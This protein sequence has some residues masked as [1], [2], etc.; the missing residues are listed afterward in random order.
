VPHSPF[1]D[2]AMPPVS[3][4]A[5]GTTSRRFPSALKMRLATLIGLL[6]LAVICT[7][8]GG[9]GTPSTV[10][11]ST[12]CIESGGRIT[13]TA[14]FPSA[15]VGS[16]FNSVVT[17]SGGQAPYQFAI[18]WG[19]LPPGLSIN[20]KT[21]TVSGTPQSAGTYNFAITATDLPHKDYGDH[22]FLLDVAGSGGHQI[23]VAISPTSATL[24]SGTTQQFTA[25]VSGT[26]NTAVTWS[27][28]LGTISS[29]GLFTAPT[30]TTTTSV[31]VTATSV[32]D[33]M[34]KA[35]AT[36]TV[37]PKSSGPTIT[38]TSIPSATEGSPYSTTLSATG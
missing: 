7:S 31:T 16:G 2:G 17:V 5:V 23:S 27:A 4:L 10:F 8:C 20:S 33:P 24:T 3:A 25:T 32:A 13:V 12:Q 9:A 34:K 11:S 26:S 21:G 35:S 36:V 19:S 28:S 37:N 38:T 6:F 18:S 29:N 14:D 22:R 1:E 15:K 30:V